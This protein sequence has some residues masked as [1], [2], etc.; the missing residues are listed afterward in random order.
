MFN[1]LHSSTNQ[2]QFEKTSAIKIATMKNTD[3]FRYEG[4]PSCAT[5]KSTPFAVSK[6]EWDTKE[7]TGKVNEEC[8]VRTAVCQKVPVGPKRRR[9]VK[10]SSP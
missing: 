2:E 5:T 9:T 10:K 3:D 7:D 4:K 6:D 8:I 1:P